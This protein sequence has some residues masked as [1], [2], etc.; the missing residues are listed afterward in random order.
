MPHIVNGHPIPEEWIRE[1]TQRIGCDLRLKATK[2]EA[3]RARQVQVAARHSA[4]D[5]ML[6][7]LAAAGDPRPIDPRVIEEEVR[8]VER[9]FRLQRTYAEM[10]AGAAHPTEEQV[11]A[12]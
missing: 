1:E 5:R 11:S 10:T 4:V 12:F 3:E 6:V 9:L 8:L 2:D 7:E